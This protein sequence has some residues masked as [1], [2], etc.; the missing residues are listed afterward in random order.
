MEYLDP[1]AGIREY[2]LGNYQPVK[3]KVLPVLQRSTE[4][5]RLSLIDTIGAEPMEQCLTTIDADLGVN[6]ADVRARGIDR[7]IKVSRDHRGCPAIEQFLDEPFLGNSQAE[8]LPDTRIEGACRSAFGHQLDPQ[9]EGTAKVELSP[10]HDKAAVLMVPVAKG[11]HSHVA[12]DFVDEH[13]KDEMRAWVRRGKLSAS[14]RKAE[15]VERN[16]IDPL[17]APQNGAI[18]GKHQ[19]RAALAHCPGRHD[20]RNVDLHWS[21]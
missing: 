17:V 15:I 9:N 7:D 10:P 16:R 8:R 11:C 1:V 6:L 12:I 3:G 21:W 19:S 13:R 14:D 2:G 5:A 18:I 20:L 4:L